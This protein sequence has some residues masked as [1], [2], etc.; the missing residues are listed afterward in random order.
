VDVLG[1]EPVPLLV[2]GAGGNV[3]LD[4]D[5]PLALGAEED[6]AVN[7]GGVDGALVPGI[8][9]KPLSAAAFCDSIMSS[10]GDT[11]RLKVGW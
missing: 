7:S 1:V 5:G 8:G 9:A 6:G 4:D 11:A 10:C 3:M 2:S